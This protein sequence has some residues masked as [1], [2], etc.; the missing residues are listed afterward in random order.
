MNQE[1]LNE[2]SRLFYQKEELLRTPVPDKS[3][4]HD[5]EEYHEATMK[6]RH[7]QQRAEKINIQYGKLL[8]LYGPELLELYSDLFRSVKK[9]NYEH[10]AELR[11]KI[12]EIEENIINKPKV[13]RKNANKNN[14][15]NLKNL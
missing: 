15:D 11:D 2:F 6:A 8:K 13:K 4:L 12:N 7:I 14:I 10:C 5:I 1:L 9:E 3:M